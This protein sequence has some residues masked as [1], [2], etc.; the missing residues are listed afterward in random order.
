MVFHGMG[1]EW[2]M[3]RLNRDVVTNGWFISEHHVINEKLWDIYHFSLVWIR[4]FHTSKKIPHPENSLF[5]FFFE[6]VS[7]SERE[8]LEE[9]FPFF[10]VTPRN[11]SDEN[12]KNSKIRTERTLNVFHFESSS[13]SHCDFFHIILFLNKEN[14]FFHSIYQCICCRLWSLYITND[15]HRFNQHLSWRLERANIIFWKSWSV[16]SIPNKWCWR[17]ISFVF[18]VESWYFDCQ[19]FWL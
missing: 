10:S 19:C 5:S 12:S 3:D 11:I 4:R 7:F 16:C 9:L 6:C 15:H 13:T 14:A 17:R 8:C 18:I 2:H 1:I